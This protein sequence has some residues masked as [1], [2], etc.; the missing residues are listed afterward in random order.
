LG[1]DANWVTATAEDEPPVPLML[2]GTDILQYNGQTS[3]TQRTEVT[4]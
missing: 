4:P 2:L 3:R 1:P